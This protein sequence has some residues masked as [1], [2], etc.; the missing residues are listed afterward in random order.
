MFIP[1][2]DV[3]TI[4]G[5][6]AWVRADKVAIVND[7]PNGHREIYV[8]GVVAVVKTKVSAEEVWDR[9]SAA[10]QGARDAELEAIRAEI[11]APETATISERDTSGSV[12]LVND[13]GGI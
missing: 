2:F 1:V 10:I 3:E 13:G 11:P 8:E 9:I 6:T 4:A 5:D 7:E 12:T